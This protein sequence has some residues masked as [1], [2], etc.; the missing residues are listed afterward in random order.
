[1]GSEKEGDVIDGSCRVG[2]EC[3]FIE[4]AKEV[5]KMEVANVSLKA[6][7][8]ESKEEI[9]MI[10]RNA[11]YSLGCDCWRKRALHTL[12]RSRCTSAAWIGHSPQF[13]FL[14]SA[15]F[16]ITSNSRTTSLTPRFCCCLERR[17]G[18]GRRC[19]RI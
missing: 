7:L 18:L 3:L 8:K 6:G 17:E 4:G 11:D 2:D 5:E 16:K 12:Q 13:I 9:N 14:T 15:R 19:N 10:G 1:M